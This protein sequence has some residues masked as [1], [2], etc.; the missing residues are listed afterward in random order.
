VPRHITLA[1]FTREAQT[2][3]EQVLI[4]RIEVLE[5]ILGMDDENQ[6]MI[7][8][9][10]KLTVMQAIILGALAKRPLLSRAALVTIVYGG[11]SE[12]DMPDVP[13]KIIDQYICK[14]R[15]NLVGH[16][17]SIKTEWAVG[18]SMSLA[19]RK[20]FETLIAAASP[21][22]VQHHAKGLL[23]VGDGDEERPRAKG[24]P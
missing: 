12:N 14:I 9:L 13:E 8:T 6:F 24:T 20:R 18:F 10:F 3:R 17:I 23:E 11:V 5:S 16:G 2:P 15:K 22:A 1:S 19:D 4:D 7:R 21:R